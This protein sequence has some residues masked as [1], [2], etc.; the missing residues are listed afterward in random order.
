MNN[1][2]DADRACG[3]IGRIERE[4]PNNSPG[5]VLFARGDSSGVRDRRGAGR[6][7][8]ETQGAAGAAYGTPLQ[9][10]FVKVLAYS[11][12][13]TELTAFTLI[14]FG[15]SRASEPISRRR[16]LAVAITIAD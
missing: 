10:G 16:L 8:G 3:R 11:S 2:A 5:F 4:R 14:L 9:E 15:L 13:P 7:S 1:H 6:R 12:A